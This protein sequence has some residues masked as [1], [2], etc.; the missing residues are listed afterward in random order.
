MSAINLVINNSNVIKS[1]E[2]IYIGTQEP[3][4][5]KKIVEIF[6]KEMN[7]PINLVKFNNKVNLNINDKT[8]FT[9]TLDPLKKLGWR[10]KF[11]VKRN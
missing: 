5:I 4:E 6:C 2:T 7:L 10:K 11:N 1:L 9:K 8:K 3:I